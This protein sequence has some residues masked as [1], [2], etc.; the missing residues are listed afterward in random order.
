MLRN[1][2]GALAATRSSNL[3]SRSLRLATHFRYMY[4][5]EGTRQCEI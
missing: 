4:T 3:A 1:I 5:D 2:R